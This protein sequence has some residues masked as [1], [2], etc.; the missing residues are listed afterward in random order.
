MLPAVIPG[1]MATPGVYYF[2]IRRQVGNAFNQPYVSEFFPVTIDG[3]ANPTPV[4]A[5][6]NTPNFGSN[7]QMGL[8]AGI[9][10]GG[11]LYAVALSFTSNTGIPIPGGHVALDADSLF[12]PEPDRRPEPLPQLLGR[13]GLGRLSVPADPDPDPRRSRRARGPDPRAGRRRRA[14]RRAHAVERSDDPH[15]LIELRPRRKARR[16]SRGPGIRVSGARPLPC[17]LPQIP[18]IP[19]FGAAAPIENLATS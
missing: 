12:S 13:P 1:G 10:H 5:A 7:F 2:E 14:R 8:S 19:G 18:L 15:P 17:P 9:P 6:L 4:L 11:E 16:S 3:P